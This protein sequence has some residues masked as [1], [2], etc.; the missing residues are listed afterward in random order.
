[1]ITLDECLELQRKFKKYCETAEQHEFPLLML[2]D[3]KME[4]TIR[5]FEN[6]SQD[7][8]SSMFRVVSQVMGG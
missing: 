6:T 8:L 4:H 2:L 1:M 7:E 3:I 5:N